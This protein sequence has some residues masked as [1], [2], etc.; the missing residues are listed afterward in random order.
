MTNDK[1]SPN[2]PNLDVLRRYVP[3]M[4]WTVIILTIFIIP[5]KIISYGFLPP[6]DA[7]ADA[8]KAVSGKSWQQILVLGPSYIMDHHLGWHWLLEKIYLWSHCSTEMLVL[9]AVTGL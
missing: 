6:D 1:G 3:L 4:V 7:L 2:F 9:V 5:L 8:A